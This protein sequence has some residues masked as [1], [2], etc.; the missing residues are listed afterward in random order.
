MPDAEGE[1]ELHLRTR[2]GGGLGVKGFAR[3]PRRLHFALHLGGF[4]QGINL[5]DFIDEFVVG[6]A[7]G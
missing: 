1:L 4:E 2:C 5:V 7:R 3:T 6:H